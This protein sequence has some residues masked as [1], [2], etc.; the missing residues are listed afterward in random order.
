MG[1]RAFRNVQKLYNIYL[2]N[3][4]QE[5]LQKLDGPHCGELEAR[6]G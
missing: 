2:V 4:Q 1:L 6:T 3:W 5:R